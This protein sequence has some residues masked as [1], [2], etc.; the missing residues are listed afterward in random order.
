M[1]A[2]ILTM[3]VPMILS[4]AIGVSLADEGDGGHGGAFLRIPVGARPAGMG[5][6]FASVAD[7]ASTLY[8]NPGG[9][10]QTEGSLVGAMY[11]IMSLDRSHFQG[12]F[13]HTHEEYGTF[14][15]MATKFGVS[16]IDGR[17]VQGNPTGTFDDSELAF[18]F[19]Y[20]REIIDRVGVG[21]A[22]KFLRHTLDENKAT[23]IGFDVGAH[24]VVPVTHDIF[25]SIRLGVSASNLGSSLEWD[26]GSS[27]Q[28]DIPSTLRIG[29]GFDLTFREIGFLIALEGSRTSDESTEFHGGVEAWLFDILGLRTGADDGNINFGVSV[30]YERFRLD[31]AL[32]ADRLEEGATSKIGVQMGF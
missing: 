16:D 28:D 3:T 12:S 23:G 14:A 2:R 24:S 11:S 10:Y 15:V 26:T 29:T 6:A 27:H 18:S 9:L 17:D 32:S 31:Y 8:F 30:L 21:G 13:I 20:G 22:F 4:A 1:N 25:K 19:G 7:D 5:N